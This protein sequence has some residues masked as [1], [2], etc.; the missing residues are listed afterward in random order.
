[1]A[2]SLVLSSSFFERMCSRFMSA[3][4]SFIGQTPSDG[5]AARWKRKDVLRAA[6]GAMAPSFVLPLSMKSFSPQ[7]LER[8]AAVS[9]PEAPGPLFTTCMLSETGAP[10]G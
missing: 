3:M 4:A 10:T 1:M 8:V 7:S 2:P 6:L 5:E 9:A